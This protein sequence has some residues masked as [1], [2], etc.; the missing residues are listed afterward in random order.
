ML[1]AMLTCANTGH[2]ALPCGK[3]SGENSPV[4]SLPGS[5]RCFDPFRLHPC[6]MAFGALDGLPV[7]ASSRWNGWG[8]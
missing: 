1:L 2:S 4:F 6:H 5:N 8:I 3:L 7:R